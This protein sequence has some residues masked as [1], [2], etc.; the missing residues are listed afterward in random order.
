MNKVV[1]VHYPVKNLPDDLK[2]GLPPDAYVSVRIDVEPAAGVAC[3]STLAGS[4]PSLHGTV[5]EVLT[6]IRSLREED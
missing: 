6:H 3:L 5:D 4:L 2:A 1:K